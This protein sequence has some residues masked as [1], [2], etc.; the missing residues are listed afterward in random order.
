VRH[1]FL[2][3]LIWIKDLD[4]DVFDFPLVNATIEAVLPSGVTRGAAHLF[5]P[6]EQGIAITI[7]IDALQFLNVPALFA[8]VP[9][10]LA[11]PTPVDDLA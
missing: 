3:H 2:V 4:T 10:F 1:S 7:D 9:I 11:T 5:D 6:Q 8:L